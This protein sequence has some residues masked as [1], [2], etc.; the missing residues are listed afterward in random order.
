MRVMIF[1]SNL[2]SILAKRMEMT[3]AL[4][5]VRT[6]MKNQAKARG[7]DLMMPLVRVTN[8]TSK[9][10]QATLQRWV[11]I[12][13]VQELSHSHKHL[14]MINPRFQAGNAVKLQIII[15]ILTYLLIFYH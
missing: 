4:L 9:T 6:L 12:L 5:V 1:T 13:M 3:I 10:F 14:T 8:L 15:Q 11:L 2:G 7:V